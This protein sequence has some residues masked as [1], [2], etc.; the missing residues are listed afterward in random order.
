MSV[1]TALQR[2]KA[3]FLASIV[4]VSIAVSQTAYDSFYLK[5]PTYKNLTALY[6][7]SKIEHADIVF[8]GNSITYGGNW[9]EL[10]GRERVVNRGIGSDNLPGMLQRL[11]QVYRLQPKLCFI[12]AGINDIYDGIAVDTIF[13]RYVQVIDSLQRHK[14][15]PIVQS[16]LHVNPKWQ[17][18]KMKN[19]DVAKLNQ[20]LQQ[21]CKQRGI[22]YVDLN[23][24]LSPH[25]VLKNEYT[26]DGV[27]LTAEAYAVWRDV[28]E[29]L[30]ETYGL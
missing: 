8:L 6:E 24:F 7:L 5:N 28:I 19:A 12:M 26:T 18:A 30:I 22:L 15:T 11:H 17:R 25:G 13:V 1:T 2:H 4:T 20:L 14:I 29:P 9:A 3:L 21:H 27:H 16:T 23:T 10:L